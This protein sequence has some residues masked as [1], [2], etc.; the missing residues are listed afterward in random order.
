MKEM[1][2]GICDTW[3]LF[4]GK[5]CYQYLILLSVILLLVFFRKKKEARLLTGYTVILLVLFF[6]PL[7]AG[8]MQKCI[9]SDV[10]W[11]VLW[12]LP[13]TV[14]LAYTGTAL[15][16]RTG[17]MAKKG[18]GLLQGLVLLVCVAAVGIS[19]KSVWSEDNY[20]QVHNYQK[21]PDGVAQVCSLISDQ[22]EDGETVCVAAD[23]YMAA[24]IRVYQ[25]DFYMPYSRAG[26]GSQHYSSMRLYQEL[27]SPDPD[28]KK[29]VKAAKRLDCNYLVFALP[30]QE[31]QEYLENKGYHLI[32]T[33]NQYGVFKLEQQ[34]S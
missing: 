22:M 7:T 5:G 32:G 20:V 2:K 9:G 28:V 17:L 4:W 34:I 15:V 10:Y 31:K 16:E 30:V 26:K 23:D 11:R 29:V 1:L 12:L 21:V 19:G 13:V 33:V 3:N 14:L 27:T 24:Y 8:I 25:P 18:K 6:F